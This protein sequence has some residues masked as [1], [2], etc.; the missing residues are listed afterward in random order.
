MTFNL[1][2]EQLGVRGGT[3]GRT[4]AGRSRGSFI[5]PGKDYLPSPE[6]PNEHTESLQTVEPGS[7]R[8]SSL[9]RSSAYSNQSE[10]DKQLA[11]EQ[12]PEPLPGC[13]GLHCDGRAPA[14][15]A[16]GTM[17]MMLMMIPSE[18]ARHEDVDGSRGSVNSR[19][20]TGGGQR[21]AAAQHKFDEIS[22]IYDHFPTDFLPEK[23]LCGVC[24]KL[25]REPRVLDCLHT[26]CRPCLDRVVATV[27]HGPDSAL[28]WHRVNESASFDWDR[29][30]W[31]R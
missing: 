30:S 29:K 19:A 28:F 5:P 26:F 16:A 12:H 14:T 18:S 24:Q 17:R 7:P 21:R 3:V 23:F 27:T 13:S 6:Q 31:G 15:P 2:P 8:K 25:L 20:S 22:T 9:R 10:L 4:S 1:T 11:V